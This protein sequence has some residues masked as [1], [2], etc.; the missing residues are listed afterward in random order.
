MFPYR[1]IFDGFKQKYC[2]KFGFTLAPDEYKIIEFGNKIS[3]LLG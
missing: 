1:F 2:S 3:L